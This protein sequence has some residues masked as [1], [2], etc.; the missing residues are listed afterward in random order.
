[1]SILTGFGLLCPMRLF[2]YQLLNQKRIGWL[3]VAIAAIS[4]SILVAA[5][6]NYETDK[7]FYLLLA[8]NLS[9]GDG[10]TIPA[11]LLSN[12]GVT[13]NIYL[14]S[15]SSPLYSII[16]APLLKFFPDNFLLVTWLI[17][18]LSWLLLFVILRKILL[19]L[20]ASHYW[21]NLYILFAGLFLYTVEVSSSSKDVLALALLFFA[22]LRCINIGNA[23]SRPG[24]VY[25]AISSVL[26]FL[27][28]LTKLTYLPLTII[29]PLCLLFIGFLKKEKRLLRYG[30]ITLLLAAVLVAVH[31]FYFHS[32]EKQ[33][34]AMYTDFYSQRWS[35]AKGGSE[36]VGG[37]YPENL[38][39]LYPFIPASVI[40]LDFVGVQVKNN[41]LSVYN[42]YGTLLYVANFIGIALMI[43]A[44]FYLIKKYYRKSV[45]DRIFFLL[46]GLFISLAIV[47]MLCIMSLRYHAV[48]YKGSTSSWTFVYESRGF[49]FPMVFL[50]LCFFV[51]LFS[52]KQTAAFT[53]WLRLFF[54][55]IISISFVHGAYFLVKKGMGLRFSSQKAMSINGLV[56]QQADSLQKTNPGYTVWLAT[57]MPH[58]D[59]Y[60]KLNGQKVLNRLTALNDSAFRL[61]PKTILLVT[62]AKE[63]RVNISKYIS[64]PGVKQVRNYDDTYFVF[65]Q[66]VKQ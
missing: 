6:S 28:G 2:L 9:A 19:R 59:W 4:K 36:Y 54:L 35:M 65:Q 41:L 66:E 63:D 61:P 5:F 26:F 8:K 30:S 25:L 12:P 50:Q 44:F 51:F 14:P 58:L 55:F 18:S 23:E 11:T 15:A 49:M 13:E 24:F 10:F 34:L 7:S 33:T 31:Y 46:A 1:M 45:S 29:F 20:T 47:A 17:E 42:L 3:F 48:E 62:V 57:E 27:P 39:V 22:L 56:T 37:F 43:T 38:K 53:H 16:A 40:N 52:K 64:K 21:T 32:L 60:A